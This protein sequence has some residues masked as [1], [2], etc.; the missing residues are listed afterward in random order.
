M[1]KEP[2][3]NEV[4]RLKIIGDVIEGSRMSRISQVAH[5]SYENDICTQ[6]CSTVLKSKTYEMH[7]KCEGSD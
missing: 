1:E 7:V 3:C 6:K 2:G 5:K 4:P